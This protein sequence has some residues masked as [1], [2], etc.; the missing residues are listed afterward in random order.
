MNRAIIG[1]KWW[2]G[3]R[4]GRPPLYAIFSPHLPSYGG[5]HIISNQN[6]ERDPSIGPFQEMPFL[7]SKRIEDKRKKADDI[8]AEPGQKEQDDNA[9]EQHGLR[10]RRDPQKSEKQKPRNL[11]V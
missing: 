1:G 2:P 3:G 7:T 8:C 9:N 4:K 11:E 5:C 6:E 10:Q